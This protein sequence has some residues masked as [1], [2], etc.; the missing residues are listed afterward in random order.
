MGLPGWI[1]P[2]LDA[3]LM[4]ATDRWAIEDRGV[5]SL[6]LMER[7][8]EGLARVVAEA[9]PEGRIAV[10]C[11]K[12]NNGGDG[13]VV[14]RLLREAGREVD[15]LM[16]APA[17]ELTDDARAVHDR[18]PGEPF[19]AARLQGADGIVDALLGTGFSGAPRDP[20]AG[21]IAAINRC[22]VPVV[23]AD[24][25]S[26]VNGSTGEVEGEAV[27][28]AAT[29]A[30]HAGK[31][32]LWVHPGKAHAGEVRVVDIG[33]PDGA[34]GEPTAGLI[35]DRVL[36]GYPR[37]GASS[38]KFDS[39]AVVVIG[40]SSGMTG[41]PSLA[42]AAAI[43]SGAGYVTLGGPG[44][45]E[46]AFSARAPVETMVRNLPEEDGGLAA[47]ALEPALEALERVDAAVLGP[48]LGRRDQTAQ[49][50]RDLAA[51]TDIPLV[52]DA[53]GLNAFE[54]SGVP[55]RGGPT[56][57]TPH[58]GELGRLLGVPSSEVKARRLHHARAAAERAQ[59]IVALKGDD[60]LVV[61]PDG[62]FAISRGDAPALAT[63]GTGDVLSGVIAAMLARGLEP[64]QA[65]CAGVWLH[66]RAGQLAA[67]RHG[68]DGV[69]A[70]DV[71]SCLP[72]SLESGL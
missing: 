71:I 68:A 63:A 54:G 18:C 14:A 4:R 41:A 34:P 52:I 24:V 43:R 33:I 26:G 16:I 66:N 5:P 50:V 51:R 31:P 36:D 40:G 53:D 1:E 22:G 23:A 9:V 67:E 49:L 69:I 59:A 64:E 61:S 28:A 65:A 15:V 32:G 11:G 70:S 20:V 2:L 57:L 55:P 30:F 21:A 38:T 48:G 7:A 47:G 19:S 27:R 12:G 25:P 60:T 35:G 45:L 46:L 72:R 39:G 6:E 56:I 44:S 58:E 17:E 3:E 10:V 42:A 8:G 29:V 13:F 37:R 62:R